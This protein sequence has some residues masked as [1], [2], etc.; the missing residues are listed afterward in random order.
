MGEERPRVKTL[1]K[2]LVLPT[3]FITSLATQPPGIIT[4]LLLIDI[5]R[6]YDVSLGVAGQIRT[7]S[8]LA[9]S[10]M[11]LFMAVLALK[12]KQKSLLLAGLLFIGVSSLGCAFAP[13]FATML[14]VYSLS[15]LGASMVFPMT[16]SIAGELY[17]S[18][19]RVGAIAWISAAGSFAYVIGAPLISFLEGIG[20]WQLAFLAFSL[21]VSFIGFLLAIRILPKLKKEQR[22]QGG[23]VDYLEGIKKVLS[24]RSAAACLVG[25]TLSMAAWTAILLYSAS[26]VRQVFQLPTSLASIYLLV[27]GV[28]FTSGT[29]V[30]GRFVNRIGMKKI[31]VLSTLIGGIFLLIHYNLSN[32]WFSVAAGSISCI[33]FGMRVTAS[34]NLSLEQLPAY[35]GSMMSLNSMIGNIGLAIGA[36]VGGLILI[37]YNYS[38]LGIFFSLFSFMAVIVIQFL[39]VDPIRG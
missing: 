33:F 25:N 14:I 35:R 15:G 3:L 21:P 18:D 8:P 34:N 5:S 23:K 16:Q 39:A 31:Y 10:M 37:L 30:S 28:L 27:L 1:G 11:G 32:F 20:G 19:D 4:S 29:L 22:T 36:G 12:Y 24:N 17:A 7:L 2:R 13:D 9:S 38:W 26:F 6:T